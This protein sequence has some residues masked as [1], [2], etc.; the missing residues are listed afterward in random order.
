MLSFDVMSASSFSNTSRFVNG[1]TIISP[2]VLLIWWVSL[3]SC[4]AM[5]SNCR[6]WCSTLITIVWSTLMTCSNSENWEITEKDFKNQVHKVHSS[7]SQPDEFNT[8]KCTHSNTVIARHQGTLNIAKLGNASVHYAN[9]KQQWGTWEQM[10][11]LALKVLPSNDAS[12]TV[13]KM[14]EF[15]Y[16]NHWTVS[17]DATAVLSASSKDN[18]AWQRD[19]EELWT[20]AGSNKWPRVMFCT[21]PRAACALLAPPQNASLL[22]QPV[23]QLLKRVFWLSQHFLQTQHVIFKWE[24]TPSIHGPQMP[25]SLSGFFAGWSKNRFFRTVGV[26]ASMKTNWGSCVQ[27][28][29]CLRGEHCSPHDR[30][31]A[32]SDRCTWQESVSGSPLSLGRTMNDASRTWR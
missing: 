26:W 23:T 6:P 2:S 16:N 25:T 14:G 29:R 32:M 15:L 11:V 31:D 27:E 5:A 21:K 7:F 9:S 28:S 18:I 12:C 10:E 1:W 30:P 19:F 24:N 3:D 8:T 22:K 17:K 20:L 13:W 4:I